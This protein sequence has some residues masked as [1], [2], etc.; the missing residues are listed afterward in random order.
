LVGG[1]VG[2]G[3]GPLSAALGLREAFADAV[4]EEHVVLAVVLLDDVAATGEESGGIAE[5]G[6]VG[7]AVVDEAFELEEGSPDE[8]VVIDAVGTAI[9]ELLAEFA[10]VAGSGGERAVF[11][12]RGRGGDA[13]L[14]DAGAL[15]DALK[16]GG[17]VEALA[18]GFEVFVGGDGAFERSDGAVEP[19]EAVEEAVEGAFAGAFEGER[20]AAVAVWDDDV[21]G[22]LLEGA[23][24][25]SFRNGGV[26]GAVAGVGHSAAGGGGLG[27]EF[28]ERVLGDGRIALSRAIGLLGDVGAFDGGEQR[29]EQRAVF[30]R[31]HERL[32]RAL[33]GFAREAESALEASLVEV[34]F[35]DG[36][37]RFVEAL[38]RLANLLGGQRHRDDEAVAALA[39]ERDLVE[40][41]WVHA[42][43][44]DLDHPVD[45]LVGV[46]DV[47][48]ED[49]V[50][51]GGAAGEVLAEAERIL[52][53]V[54]DEA[55]DGDERGDQDGAKR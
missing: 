43:L 19:F 24:D 23:A 12:G 36:G 10:F 1:R 15:E 21:L 38:T 11:L 47:F 4:G 2:V 35:S 33:A 16:V 7:G 40:P 14:E 42:V 25:A 34:V 18:D 32:D 37:D 13:E 29:L 9:L 53:R 31:V 51:E 45:G 27:E 28:V 39:D 46:V 22:A 54:E 3:D 6:V 52:R 55:E 20:L 50:G 26:E 17:I 41:A 8:L 48:K 44:E 30:R 49:G 5:E